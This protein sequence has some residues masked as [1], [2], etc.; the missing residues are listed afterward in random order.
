MIWDGGVDITSGEESCDRDERASHSQCALY[1]V[2]KCQIN[3]LLELYSH[4]RTACSPL[5]RCPLCSVHCGCVP[6]LIRGH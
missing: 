2:S 3:I 5:A 6:S 1:N 4:G